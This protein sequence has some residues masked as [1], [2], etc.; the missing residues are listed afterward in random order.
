MARLEVRCN[1]LQEGYQIQALLHWKCSGNLPSFEL[2]FVTS[3]SYGNKDKN[4]DLCEN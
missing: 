1:F 2:C 4:A 3:V